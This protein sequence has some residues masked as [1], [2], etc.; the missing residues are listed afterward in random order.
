MFTYLYQL[1]TLVTV[2]ALIIIPLQ[3]VYAA[4]DFITPSKTT[5][6]K[7]TE[8]TGD[9]YLLIGTYKSQ[10]GNNNSV[11]E[12]LNKIIE[13]QPKNASA[14]FT[15]AGIYYEQKNYDLALADINQAIKLNFNNPVF[16]YARGLIYGQQQKSD[17]ALADL[18]QTI[19]L[20]PYYAVAYNNR[21]FIYYEQGKVKEA[22]KD[23]QKTISI[24]TTIAEAYLALAVTY[25]S[26][27]DENKAYK[28]AEKAFKTDNQLADVSYLKGEKKWS[29]KLLEHTQKLRETPRVKNIISKLK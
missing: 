15:R 9:Q 5:E 27:G 24:D 21:G 14:Y 17:L 25:Y 18:N 28:L 19:K 6:N 16:Y 11:L 12:D 4:D 7:I 23:W 13:Q 8:A 3:I 26:Q 2:S 20:S 10:K 1:S 29:N 22:V